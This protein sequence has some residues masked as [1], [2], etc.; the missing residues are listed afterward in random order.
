MCT[1]LVWLAYPLLCIS[2][3]VTISI[4]AE[5]YSGS[6]QLA[7]VSPC[8][9]TVLECGSLLAGLWSQ[10]N[11]TWR[12]NGTELD[13]DIEEVRRGQ[14]LSDLYVVCFVGGLL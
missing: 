5:E 9:V 7:K 6:H 11:F 2:V 8:G 10:V 13:L 14:L 4:P 1:L 3:H 12:R